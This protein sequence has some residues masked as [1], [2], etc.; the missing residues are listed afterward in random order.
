MAV[1]VEQLGRAVVLVVDGDLDLHTAP[2]ARQAI[3]AALSHRPRRLIVDLSLVRFLN[4][5]GLE[6]LLAAQRQAA[7]HTDL[8]LVATTRAVWRPLQITRLHERLIIHSSRSA[9]VASPARTGDEDRS[10]PRKT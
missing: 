4:S 2:A 10:P 7:P 9:A 3:E 5:T 6:V 8:R 1:T